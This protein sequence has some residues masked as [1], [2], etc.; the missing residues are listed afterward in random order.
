MYKTINNYIYMYN[1]INLSEHILNIPM[2]LYRINNNNFIWKN[3]VPYDTLQGILRIKIYY[4]NCI[5]L[6]WRIT[7]VNV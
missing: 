4:A 2:Y 7:F 3:K 1:V 5:H 6:R